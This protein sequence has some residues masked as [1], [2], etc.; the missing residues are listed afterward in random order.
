MRILKQLILVVL[1]SNLMFACRK[2]KSDISS[3]DVK[4][5]LSNINH[6]TT[7]VDENGRKWEVEY[8]GAKIE[9][10]SN[11]I[12]GPV[13]YAFSMHRDEH[14]YDKYGK[15]AKKIYKDIYHTDLYHISIGDDSLK[16][17]EVFSATIW[18]KFDKYLIEIE[19]PRKETA[20]NKITEED[21]FEFTCSEK[22]T[23][24]FIG[25][26]KS[27]SASFSFDYKFIVN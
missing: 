20:N 19:E 27:D 9:D 12:N 6:D 10:I 5:R 15:I 16:V 14:L 1:L 26:V 17:G 18:S 11:S 2:G 13:K 21:V 22:G 4:E 25:K 8:N 7:F 3:E 23:Y 24:N